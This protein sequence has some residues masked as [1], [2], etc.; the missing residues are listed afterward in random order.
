MG[1]TVMDYILET[2]L[3]MA[4]EILKEGSVSVTEVGS[5][6]GF[7]RPAY[8]SRVFKERVGVSPKKFRTT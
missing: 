3:A 7:S 8:F 2:R 6:C 5:T 4:K 1:L